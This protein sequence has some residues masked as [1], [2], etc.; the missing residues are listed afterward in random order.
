M[1]SDVKPGIR[2]LLLSE[3]LHGHVTYLHAGG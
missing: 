2:L 1:V 3:A